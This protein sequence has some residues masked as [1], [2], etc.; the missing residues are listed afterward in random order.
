M[1]RGGG[2]DDENEK[3]EVIECESR[4]SDFGGCGVEDTEQEEC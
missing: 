2:G 3:E 1:R 4:R